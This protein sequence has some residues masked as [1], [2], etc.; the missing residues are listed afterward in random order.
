[1]ATKGEMWANNSRWMTGDPC[2]EEWFG[3]SCTVTLD[4]V[5]SL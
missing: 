5:T 1:M 4:A 2:V 3:V